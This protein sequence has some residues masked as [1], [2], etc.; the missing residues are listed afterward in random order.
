MFLR[1][2]QNIS[3]TTGPMTASEIY[4]VPDHEGLSM[5]IRGIAEYSTMPPKFIADHYA[6]LDQYAGE[7]CL[8]LPPYGWEFGHLIMSHVPF[9]F[10]HEASHKIVACQKGQ[11]A[12]FPNADGFY[13]NWDD[14]VPD[15]KRIGTGRGVAARSWPEIVAKYP[16][17]KPILAGP[18]SMEQE[19]IPYFPTK[20]INFRANSSL[21]PVIACIGPRNRPEFEIKR[22]WSHWDA[23]GRALTAQGISFAV[24]GKRPTAIDVRG[25]TTHTDGDCGAAL[26]LL[27]GCR[28][29]IG[30]CSG[31]SHLA[32]ACQSPMLIFREKATA[33]RNFIPHMQAVNQ[34]KI[35][36][37]EDGFN[38]PEKVIA[39][40]LNILCPTSA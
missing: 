18:L 28:L 29:F 38:C 37:I 39:A 10:H 16:D 12:L 25:Q 11:E 40:A 2:L 21:K 36:I 6:R 31:T 7:K 27:A 3:T 9:V 13:T 35:T 5:C 26:H 14:T 19:T 4:E 20:P 1:I 32:A 34:N 22:N 15:S 30:T 8:F 23:L 33:G 17:H 24:I